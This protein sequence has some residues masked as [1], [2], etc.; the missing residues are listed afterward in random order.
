[1]LLGMRVNVTQKDSDE[2]LVM[3]PREA[4]AQRDEGTRMF[5]RRS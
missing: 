1:M 2:W 5:H 3:L 4:E